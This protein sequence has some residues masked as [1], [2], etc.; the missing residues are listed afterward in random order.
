MG[1]G[2]EALRSE[3]RVTPVGRNGGPVTFPPISGLFKTRGTVAFR[4]SPEGVQG[5]AMKRS[6]FSEEQIA[7]ALR[8]AES[9]TPVIDVC[10]QIG[11]SEA[12]YYTWKKK[13]GDLG[14]TELKR[15]KMLEDENARLKRIVADLTLDKQI[16]QEVVRKK[17]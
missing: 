8:L 15:L 5:E 13:F 16:L 7:Y 3:T 12:T 4:G 2:C 1:G 6:R 9:G 17:L 10:R 14:V 11:V